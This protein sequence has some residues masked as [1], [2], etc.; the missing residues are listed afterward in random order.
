MK[1]VFPDLMVVTLIRIIFELY[2]HILAN[3]CGQYGQL[4]C[5]EK[6]WCHLTN[7]LI[8]PVNQWSCI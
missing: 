4:H 7:S 8:H 6:K 2:S 3:S 1:K 5:I